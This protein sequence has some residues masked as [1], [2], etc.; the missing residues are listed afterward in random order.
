VRT[1]LATV[2]AALSLAVLASAAEA[3][4][5]PAGALTLSNNHAKAFSRV[6]VDLDPRAAGAGSKAPQALFVD[7]QRGARFDPR[8][9]KRRCNDEQAGRL[10]C[11]RKA[12]I[13]SGLVEGT[14]RGLYVPGGKQDF[15]V[16]LE[17]FVA[18]PRHA[19]DLA[20]VIAQY[21][22]PKSGRSGFRRARVLPLPSGPFGVE[23]EIDVPAVPALPGV[24]A[25]L[26]RIRLSAGGT[27]RYRKVRRKRVRR[28][29]H[30]R[31]KRVV[32]KRRRSLIVNPPTCAGSWATQLRVQY[33][34][35][36]NT[37]DAQVPC[38]GRA[39]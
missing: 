7:F 22:E 38:Q 23:V 12:R 20:D 15:A 19:G 10:A 32:R 37:Y 5:A 3:A 16:A 31:I 4:P 34:D 26:R 17:L 29:G 30:V 35:H 6:F 39:R 21:R 24:T 13:G 18:K 2:A 27:A 28:H 36:T 8:G 11:P 1:P 14:V 9:R 25:E 33:P